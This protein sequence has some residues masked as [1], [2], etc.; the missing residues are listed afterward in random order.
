MKVQVNTDHSIE[1]SEGMA[2]HV[3]GLVE[4]A[5]RNHANRLTRV[6]VH[7]TDVN[8]GKSGPEDKQCTIE[9][10]PEGLQPMAATDNADG[11]DDAVRGAAHK[12]SRI[13]DSAFGKAG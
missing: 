5:L 6:E 7:L 3:S 9:V 10:R 12:V 2:N 13:L 8:A 1:A 4:H 11:I